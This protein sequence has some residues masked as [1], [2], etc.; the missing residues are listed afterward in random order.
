MVKTT[1]RLPD[2]V[3]DALRQRS[4]DESKSINEVVVDALREGLGIAEDEPWWRSLEPLGITPPQRK[5][6]REAFRKEQEELWRQLGWTA[7]QRH[8]FARG[9]FEELDWLRSDSWERAAPP[10]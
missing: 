7:Q 6:D 10:S 3:A 9:L 8:E 4:R 5:F 1:I 2:R